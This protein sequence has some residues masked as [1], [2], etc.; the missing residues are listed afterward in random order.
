MLMLTLIISFSRFKLNN[1]FVI[2]NIQHKLCLN[3]FYSISDSDLFWTML[4]FIDAEQWLEL[5]ND[6]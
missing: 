4:V 5:L 2:K 6:P 3:F 1:F